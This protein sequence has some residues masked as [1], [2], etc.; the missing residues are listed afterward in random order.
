LYYYKIIQLFKRIPL[1]PFFSLL[2]NILWNRR[3][4][5]PTLSF[6]ANISNTFYYKLLLEALC[7]SAAL[8][9]FTLWYNTSKLNTYLPYTK[10]TSPYKRFW[11][12][13][14]IPNQIFGVAIFPK[15][16]FPKF[17]FPNINFPNGY[18]P[19]LHF[20]EVQFH[21]NQ[22]FQIANRPARFQLTGFKSSF[23]IFNSIKQ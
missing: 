18:L 3:I 11:K 9:V 1:F 12:Q 17:Y 15:P 13:V 20:P 4:K 21:L 22:I 23:N 7:C 2:T 8:T 6:I 10:P 16:I 14:D 19:E 5:L